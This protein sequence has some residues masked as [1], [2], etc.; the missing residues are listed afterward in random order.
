VDLD[1][2]AAPAAAEP[3]LRK[4]YQASPSLEVRPGSSDIVVSAGVRDVNN[5]ATYIWV[6]LSSLL[7]SNETQ[8]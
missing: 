5:V 6:N 7:D 1:G 3:A 4:V 2:S 8:A